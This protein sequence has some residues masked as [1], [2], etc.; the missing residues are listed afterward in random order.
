MCSGSLILGALGLLDKKRATTYPTAVE[1][2]RALGVEVVDEPFVCEGRVATAAACLAGIDLAGWAIESL[3]GADVRAQVL[4]E[5]QP[6]GGA[7]I[8]STV[9]APT[10]SP[11]GSRSAA[12]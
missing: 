3:L 9:A 11:A 10:A 7:R 2:L 4:S 5:V 8:V 6:V 12:G 1:A